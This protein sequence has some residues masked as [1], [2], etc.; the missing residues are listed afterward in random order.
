[1]NCIKFYSTYTGEGSLLG[2]K[3]YL[4]TYFY[5]KGFDRR[6]IKIGHPVKEVYPEKFKYVFNAIAQFKE[7]CGRV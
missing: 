3:D 4:G 5:S 2:L 1:M 7:R 6:I